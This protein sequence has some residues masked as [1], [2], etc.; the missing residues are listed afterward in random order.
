MLVKKRVA[1]S[2]RVNQLTT[3]GLGRGRASSDTTLVAMMITF[4]V[5]EVDRLYRTASDSTLEIEVSQP[6]LSA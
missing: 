5:V 1:G 6:E 4:L 3:A 2:C